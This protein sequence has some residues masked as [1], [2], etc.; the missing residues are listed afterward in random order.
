MFNSLKGRKKL[1]RLG[2]LNGHLLCLRPTH[3]Q[4]HRLARS[5]HRPSC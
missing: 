5:P 2:L 3:H 4:G 1:I